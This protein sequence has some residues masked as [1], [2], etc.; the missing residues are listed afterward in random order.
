MDRGG[1]CGL[2]GL[3]GRAGQS[4]RVFVVCPGAGA[5]GYCWWL[6]VV[7]GCLRSSV[8]VG[9][10]WLYPAANAARFLLVVSPGLMPGWE[11]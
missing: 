9:W 11:K 4:G 6:V 1:H 3:S 2:N 10:W 5:L 7:S 8:S